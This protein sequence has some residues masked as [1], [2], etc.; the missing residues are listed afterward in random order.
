VTEAGGLGILGGGYGD[1]Q[2]L[3]GELDR[4]GERRARFGIGFITWSLAKQPKLLDIALERSPAAVMLSFGDP[5]PFVERIKAA[6]AAVI[7]Q[8]QSVAMAREAVAAGADVLVAQGAEGGGHGATRGLSTLLPEIVDAF[9][10][11]SLVTGAG[12]IA[13]GRGLAAALMLGAD[14][15]LM[16]TRFYATTEAAAANA[17]KQRICAAGGDD[18]QR[19]IVFDIS[20][21]NVWPAPFTG[22][23]LRNQHLDAWYGREME[24]LRNQDAESARYAAAR[25]A[26][27]FD[28][29]AVIAGESSGL[30]HDVFARPRGRATH[31][32]RR[33]RAVEPRPAARPGRGLIPRVPGQGWT[34]S[35]F[36]T[37]DCRH[38]RKNLVCPLLICDERSVPQCCAH[39]ACFPRSSRIAAATLPSTRCTRCR[40]KSAATPSAFQWCSCTAVPVAAAR[41]GTANSST[42]R[43][44]G[45]CCS[46]SAARGTRRRS[47]KCATTRRSTWSTTSRSCGGMLE[48]ERWLVFG[49]SWGST[50]A[51]AYGEANP[52]ALPRFRSARHLPR[53]PGRARLVHGRH[54]TLLSGGAAQIHRGAAARRNAPMR[55]PISTGG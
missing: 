25:T 12:G 2:W 36:E 48:I 7:C 52:K 14:G 28:I 4:L 11:Q 38:F 33:G 46:T 45:S 15:V 27:N 1:E 41:R 51:L 54:G 16:G 44:T 23:C 35:C 31:G 20:R 29:A 19:S 55:C 18:T 30:V 34:M 49:G 17:A 5:A 50:L 9:G 43:S 39:D 22:R 26:A 37:G 8:V 53:A 10:D 3:R 13:D 40:G 32:A 21:R 42:R 47:A 24:L 6:G